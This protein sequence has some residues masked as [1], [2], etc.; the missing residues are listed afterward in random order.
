VVLSGSGCGPV[1][2]FCE[3]DMNHQVVQK[4]FPIVAS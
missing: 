3:N 2:C 1:S 4:L